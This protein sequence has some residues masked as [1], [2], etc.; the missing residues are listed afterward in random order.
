MGRGTVKEYSPG[1]LV[2]WFESYADG[3]MTKAVGRGIIL[4]RKVH[5][6]GFPSGPYITYRVYRTEHTD[7]MIFEPRELES[8]EK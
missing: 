2:R 8:I 3:F 5:N 6:L 7:E 1:D 4:E